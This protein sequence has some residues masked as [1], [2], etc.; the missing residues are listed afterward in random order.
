MV[1]FKPGEEWPDMRPD[2]MHI[3]EMLAQ[4]LDKTYQ[5]KLFVEIP[6]D[7]DENHTGDIIRAAKIYCRRQKKALRH[8]MS[9]HGRQTVLRLKMRDVRPYVR[10]SDT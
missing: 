10:K 2:A 5:E 9:Q 7:P 1:K 8:E 3:P 6:V 4:W